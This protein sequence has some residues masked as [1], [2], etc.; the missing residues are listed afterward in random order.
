MGYGIPSLLYV[1][2][3]ML[4]QIRDEDLLH[5]R[6]LRDGALALLTAV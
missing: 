5:E 3:R 6:Q 1:L 2:R 4:M